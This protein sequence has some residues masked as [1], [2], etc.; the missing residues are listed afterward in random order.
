MDCLDLGSESIPRDGDSELSQW[1]GDEGDWDCDSLLELSSDEEIPGPSHPVAATLDSLADP[2]LAE[3]AFIALGREPGCF[4]TPIVYALEFMWAPLLQISLERLKYLIRH[5]TFANRVF[6]LRRALPAF[7]ALIDS[8]VCF[9][10]DKCCCGGRKF[11]SPSALVSHFFTFEFMR[12]SAVVFMQPRKVQYYLMYN[13]FV[14]QS[15]EVW[16]AWLDFYH[17][18]MLP[19]MYGPESRFVSLR[20]HVANYLSALTGVFHQDS[21]GAFNGWSA[22]EMPGYTYLEPG[23]HPALPITV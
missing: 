20:E 19:C 23:D 21:A 16:H 17:Y 15:D 8:G 22:Q 18:A 3:V 2:A 1:S 7:D 14:R 12:F 10:G 6:V 4:V 5:G 9:F 11:T 13:F